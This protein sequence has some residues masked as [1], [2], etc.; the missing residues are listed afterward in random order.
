MLLILAFQLVILLFS[1]ILHEVS[2][3]L[4]AFRLGD[5]TA[6][7]AGRL[8]LN[9]IKHLDPFGSFFLPVLLYIASG[10][11]FVFGWAKPVPYNPNFL[12]DP[13]RG[14]GLIAAA[15]PLT[16]LSLALF[17]GTLSRVLV[18]ADIAALPTALI[19][20]L[21]MIVI[22]NIVLAVFNLVPIPPLDGSKVLFSILPEGEVTW[23]AQAFL[24]RYGI[25]ILI[26]FMLYGFG[27]LAPLVS[28]LFRFI[29]GDSLF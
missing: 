6:K 28:L 4:M 17:F 25:I 12:K 3:G 15:G 23:K 5:P 14:G 11:S 13:K 18:A 26:L 1:V 22:V 27:F 20:L 21:H 2:H 16:N 9:P 8:T 29:T 10:G 19:P 24:E 7:L